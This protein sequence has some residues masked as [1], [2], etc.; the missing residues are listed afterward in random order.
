MMEQ[1]I[2]KKKFPT[3]IGWL[4]VGVLF[5]PHLLNL[6]SIDIMDSSWFK[7]GG[8]A[9]KM[10]LGVL[11]VINL[12]WE[13]LKKTGG[14]VIKLTLSQ[15]SGSSIVAAILCKF[16]NISLLIALLIVNI[17]ITLAPRPPL[18]VRQQYKPVGL[19]RDTAA[20][21]VLTDSVLS[22]IVFYTI[23]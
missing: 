17:F 16:F 15:I 20:T 1:F 4:L 6:F 19:L 10:C 7:Y 2:Q 12:R 22:N 13:K 9:G 11:V 5:G 8:I 21:V 18:A 3:V 23:I 14:D